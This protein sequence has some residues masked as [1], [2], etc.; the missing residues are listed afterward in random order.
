MHGGHFTLYGQEPA[1]SIYASAPSELPISL[2]QWFYHVTDL[3]GLG[4]TGGCWDLRGRVADYLGFANFGSKRVL[5]VG[6]ASGFLTTEMERLGAEVVA[7]DVSDEH[8]WDF[9][10]FPDSILNEVNTWRP[11]H[12]AKMKAAFW[13]NHRQNRLN[14]KLFHGDIY[15]LPDELGTFDIALL[16]AVLLHTE[17]PQRIIMECAKRAKTLIITDIHHPDLDG[18]GPI[19]RLHPSASNKD[20]GTW[21]HF[22]PAYVQQFLEVMGFATRT[23]FHQQFEVQQKVMRGYFT[24][25]AT[26][27]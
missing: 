15:N 23:N 22:T 21:W 4:T 20:W 19:V 25:V 26:R 12:M 9:V 1:G 27:R 16:G 18:M 7:V 3:P 10:P 8:G 14:A 5:E 6:P 2:M 24:I 17:N 13:L 11:E